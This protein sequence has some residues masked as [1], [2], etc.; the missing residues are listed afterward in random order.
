LPLSAAESVRDV[1]ET[2]TIPSGL[3]IKAGEEPGR[4]ETL[5]NMV[6]P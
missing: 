1:P 2:V 5:F 6:V 4:N 3:R